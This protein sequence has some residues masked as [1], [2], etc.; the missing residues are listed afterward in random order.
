[1]PGGITIPGVVVGG[2]V[3]GLTVVGAP[4]VGASVDPGAVVTGAVVTGAVVT[5]AVVAGEVVE[6]GIE[7]G[8]KVDDGAGAVGSG[9]TVVDVTVVDVTV[10]DVTVV[11]ASWAAAAPTPAGWAAMVKPKQT[12]IE[13]AENGRFMGRKSLAESVDVSA[14][15]MR[16]NT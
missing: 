11:L 2:T 13:A 8:L 5:G 15:R 14:S 4:V 10:V 6:V 7:V 9:V 1:L 12:S 3:V 16:P